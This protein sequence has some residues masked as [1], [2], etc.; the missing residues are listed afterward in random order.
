MK[1]SANVSWNYSGKPD[2]FHGTSA[3]SAEKALTWLAA[4]L[5]VAGIAT[6]SALD[7]LPGWSLWQTLLALALGVD[8]IGGLIANSLNSC[9]QF[10]HAP[11]QSNER[12][13]MKRHWL[14]VA[15]HVHPIV[16]GLAFGAIAY[17]LIWY[18]VLQI[19]TLVVR[20]APLYLRRPLAMFWT[21]AAIFADL[22]LLEAIP[23]L[24]WFIPV[25]F[26]KIVYGHSVREEPYRPVEPTE[27]SRR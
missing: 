8:L 20:N 2:P 22:Y 16:F 5:F 27:P 19:A 18:V 26:L 3:T 14:F 21:G 4:A 12:P 9:K 7:R 24:E 11:L 17:G 13:W 23:G 1:Q 6:V 25:L 15:L 10:F